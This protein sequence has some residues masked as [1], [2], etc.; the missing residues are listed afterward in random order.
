MAADEIIM[1]IQAG[2]GCHIE[3]RKM[4]IS[5]S[6]GQTVGNNC[7]M[8]FSLHVVKSVDDKLLTAKFFWLILVKVRDA[9]LCC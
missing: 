7:K 2:S 6:R 1:K 8:A 5:I 3:F 9:Q 4:S